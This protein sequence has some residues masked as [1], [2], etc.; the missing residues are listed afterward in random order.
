MTEQ[1][2]IDLINTEKGTWLSKLGLD[3]FCSY[4]AEDDFYIAEVKNRRDYYPTKM[5]EALKLFTNY[6]KA[7]KKGKSF[8]YIVTDKSGLYVFNISRVID[9]ILQ[10]GI[11]KTRQPSTTDFGD[12]R[13]ILKYVYYI[14]EALAIFTKDF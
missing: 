2:T 11:K 5:I 6:H 14:P 8:L 9:E 4:D 10:T 3:D 13:K 7:Q 12:D 1:E